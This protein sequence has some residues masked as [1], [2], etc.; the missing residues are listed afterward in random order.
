MN[1]FGARIK[2]LRREKGFTQEELGA[3]IGIQKSGVAKYENGKIRSVPR[4]TLAALAAALSVT[5]DYLI[6][7][8]ESDLRGMDIV[9]TPTHEGVVLSDDGGLFDEEVTYTRQEWDA[10]CGDAAE[11]RRR[12]FDDFLA[13]A[14]KPAPVSEDELTPAQRR[15][16]EFVKQMDDETLDRFIAAAKAF[17]K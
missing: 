10:M 7:K 9:V 5:E 6:G 4:E 1:N 14:K 2:S 16:W 11:G 15:A 13:A 12:V 17:I 8:L 3:L